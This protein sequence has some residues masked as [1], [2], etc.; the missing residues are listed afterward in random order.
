MDRDALANMLKGK[1]LLAIII[2]VIVVV[3]AAAAYVVLKDDGGSGGSRTTDDLVVE[4]DQTRDIDEDMIIAGDIRVDEGA[5]LNV[6][7]GVTI[8][9]TDPDAKINVAGT[10]NSE[11]TI[12]FVRTDKEGNTDVVYTNGTGES[13]SI[14]VTGTMTL[15]MDNFHHTTEWGDVTFETGIN[16]FINGAVCLIDEYTV[17]VTNLQNAANTEDIIGDIVYVIGEF[18]N[19][20]AASIP[21]DVTVEVATGAKPTFGTVTLAN[22]A[23]FDATAGSVTATFSNGGNSV[24]MT[25]GSGMTVSAVEYNK[26]GLL[27][28]DGD[29]S[30]TMSIASGSVYVNNLNVDNK[31]SSLTVDSGS[32]LILKDITNVADGVLKTSTVTTSGTTV[33]GTYQVTINGSMVIGDKP[34]STTA[35]A[36]DTTAGFSGNVYI[37]K[38]GYVK[39]YAGEGSLEGK[40][41]GFMID[42][43]AYMTIYGNVSIAS[44]LSGETV[45]ITGITQANFANVANWN[46]KASQLGDDVAATTNVA[47]TGYE[48]V[49]YA[50]SVV[51][52]N[53]DNNANADITIDGVLLDDDVKSISIAVG[54]YSYEAKITT[55]STISKLGTTTLSN[56]IEIPSSTTALT[57]TVDED[58]TT[59]DG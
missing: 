9:L 33:T 37:G 35:T 21:A 54:K 22:G 14:T 49:Y 43:K 11:G 6:A 29:A 44:A 30:G 58:N 23:E 39:V 40:G 1:T 25:A 59:P 15:P 50:T 52:V 20:T 48:I 13:R 18:S 4:K 36:T 10:M 42:G 17:K 46:N 56:D 45:G 47:D 32:T 55:G 27:V 24:K 3:A 57:L 16:G 12:E 41:T 19:N 5:T 8:T 7:S 28:L 51:T 34:T 26:A 31:G 38:D 53:I 2:V